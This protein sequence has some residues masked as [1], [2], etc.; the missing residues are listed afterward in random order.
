MS[1][2]SERCIYCHTELRECDNDPN[3]EENSVCKQC[4]AEMEHDYDLEP[5]VVYNRYGNQV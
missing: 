2:E 3:G 1:E 4:V 5:N